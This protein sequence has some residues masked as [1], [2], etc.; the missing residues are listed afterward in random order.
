MQA[1]KGLL[2]FVA[3]IILSAV[4]ITAIWVTQYEANPPKITLLNKPEK[5]G[6]KIV[7]RFL[8]QD[9]EKGLRRVRVAVVQNRQSRDVPV[10]AVSVSATAS[11][12]GSAGGQ[13]DVQPAPAVPRAQKAPV[14]FRAVIDPRALGLEDN[15]ATIVVQAWD[16]AWSNGFRGNEARVAFTVRVDTRP[17]FGVMATQVLYLSRGGAGLVLF[18]T[19]P[20]AERAEARVVGA[21]FRARRIHLRLWQALIACPVDYRPGRLRP[22]LCPNVVVTAWDRAGNPFRIHLVSRKRTPR[23]MDRGRARV[24]LT[25]DFL[26]RVAA[27]PEY[28]RPS[29][30]PLETFQRVFSQ[31][32]QGGKKIIDVLSRRSPRSITWKQVFLVPLAAARPVAKFGQLRTYVYA[33]R[34][35][36]R[37]LV[38]GVDF[39]SRTR[40][41]P[42]LAANDGRVVLAGF[43]GPYGNTVIIDHGLGLLSLYGHLSR[44]EPG[45]RVGDP[46]ARG[47]IIGRAGRSG[48]AMREKL[49][50]AMMIGSVFVDP[51][52][53]WD[54]NWLKLNVAARYTEAGLNEYFQL[55]EKPGPG[56]PE[57]AT[58]R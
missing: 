4:A 12:P 10:K 45:L 53:W 19:S 13:A 55:Q 39:V 7:L 17:P 15:P 26:N 40:Q 57:P 50:F 38:T 32:D 43:F 9:P 5:I 1:L 6:E 51:Y 46:V 27:V 14:E 56:R 28:R 29:L 20:D 25:A 31:F 44:I 2:Y 16:R 36:V 18:R 47:R 24:R 48:L 54:W 21:R 52:E 22:R 41:A 37:R 35:V 3:F 11:G 42:V 34:M 30:G 49:H 8:V 58:Q 33:D 23:W